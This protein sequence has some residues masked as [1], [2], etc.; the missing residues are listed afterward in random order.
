MK[1]EKNFAHLLFIIHYSLL[2]NHYVTSFRMT[3]VGRSEQRKESTVISR[4]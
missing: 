3:G 1:N 4:E 2:V